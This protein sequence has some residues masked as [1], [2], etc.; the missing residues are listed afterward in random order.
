MEKTFAY[1]GLICSECPA[2]LATRA[3]DMAALEKVAAQWSEEY[4]RSITAD[5]CLCDGCTSGSERLC[6]YCG[7]CDVRACAI[8]RGV[9]TCAHCDNYGC[10]TITRFL[11]FAPQAKTGLEEIRASL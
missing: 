1:C 2:Y 7:E 4:G 11:E 10:Q 6:G 8:E 5:Y 9:L 3:E